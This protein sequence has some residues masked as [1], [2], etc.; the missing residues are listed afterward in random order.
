MANYHEHKCL[1]CGQV[2]DYCGRCVIT[3]VMYKAEGFCSEQ[4][5]H[6]FAILSKHGC[7]LITAE[8]VLTELEAYNIDEMK[9]TD[10]VAAHIERIK[11]EVKVVTVEVEPEKTDKQSNQN[12]KKKW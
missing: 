6:I 1:T 10:D 5:S 2:F 7:N 9:L 12:N 4:C 11:S 8:E 3:P